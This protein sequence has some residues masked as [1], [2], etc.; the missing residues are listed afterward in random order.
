MR[1]RDGGEREVGEESFKI[2]RKIRRKRCPCVWLSG[3]HPVLFAVDVY[4]IAYVKCSSLHAQNTLQP[5]CQLMKFGIMTISIKTNVPIK[6]GASEIICVEL[7]A[8]TL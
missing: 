4:G 8:K 1:R 6:F 5:C 3:F 2:E 7:R